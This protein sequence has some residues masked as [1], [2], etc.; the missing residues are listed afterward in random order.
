M[1]SRDRAVPGFFVVGC[2]RPFSAL[3]IPMGQWLWTALP[4]LPALPASV[5]RDRPI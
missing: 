2:W 3:L 5:R 4:A 1:S